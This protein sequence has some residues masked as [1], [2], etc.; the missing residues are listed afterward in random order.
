MDY[1]ED[2]LSHKPH[3][4]LSGVFPVTFAG[5][6]QNLCNFNESFQS[7]PAYFHVA[8]W[9]VKRRGKTATPPQSGQLV[10]SSSYIPLALT[11]Y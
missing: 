9:T 11:E 8:L 10:T 1:T 7:F 5:L 6:Q 4:K 2:P 3:P